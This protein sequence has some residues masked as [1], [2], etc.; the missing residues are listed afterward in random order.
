MHCHVDDNDE[1]GRRW[2]IWWRWRLGRP[3][4]EYRSDHG[5]VD[6]T[7][8]GARRDRAA[9]FGTR[10]H[11]HDESQ[12]LGGA[13]TTVGVGLLH[14]DDEH[15]EHDDEHHRGRSGISPEGPSAEYRFVH[16]SSDESSD[17]VATTVGSGLLQHDNHEHRGRS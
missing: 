11:N 10:D 6:S 14:H 13:G 2:A 7:D 16:D 1:R 9:G 3:S 5:S 8:R 12:R 17:G 4:A 15:L